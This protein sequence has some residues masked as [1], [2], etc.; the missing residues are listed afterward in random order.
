[1]KKEFLN[2][3]FAKQC[4]PIQCA[5]FPKKNPLFYMTHA[6]PI[7]QQNAFSTE[8]CEQIFTFYLVKASINEIV[9]SCNFLGIMGI[10]KG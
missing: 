8:C 5:S 9:E 10:V 4:F 3:S 7:I 2:K 6:K 1:M